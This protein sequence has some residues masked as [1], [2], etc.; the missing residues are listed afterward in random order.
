MYKL[1]GEMSNGMFVWNTM[2]WSEQNRLAGGDWYTY[3]PR[4]Q[5]RRYEERKEKRLHAFTSFTAC[6]CVSTGNVAR[7]GSSDTTASHCQNCHHITPPVT[8][9]ETRM[10]TTAWELK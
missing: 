5:C 8:S 3:H 2:N 6:G 10:K 1:V 7:R 9:T 4:N